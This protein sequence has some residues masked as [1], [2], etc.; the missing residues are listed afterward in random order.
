M[1]KL[2]AAL[3]HR[4]A[5]DEIAPVGLQDVL[6]QGAWGGCYPLAGHD[7]FVHPQV[8]A[9]S[10]SNSA[11]DR[12]VFE[13]VSPL[14]KRDTVRGG[15]S[16]LGARGRETRIVMYLCGE[17]NSWRTECLCLRGGAVTILFV[18]IPKK[19]DNTQKQQLSSIAFS[20]RP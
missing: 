16:S 8:P 4:V 5:H 11:V 7:N 2:L 6:H 20:Q 14:Q 18:Q 17:R 10:R 9:T 15:G 3:I 13:E 1:K 12:H 19:R